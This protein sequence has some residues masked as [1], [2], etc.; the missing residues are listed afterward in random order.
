MERWDGGESM[1]A[2]NGHV[3]KV[4]TV[5]NRVLTASDTHKEGHGW[6]KMPAEE[7]ECVSVK[8]P[9]HCAKLRVLG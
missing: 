4:T 1:A 9:R 7:E 6:S 3:E 2:S 5:R 8:I